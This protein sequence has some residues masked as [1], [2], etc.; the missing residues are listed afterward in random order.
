[1]IEEFI[2]FVYVVVVV[3]F[4]YGLKMFGFFVMVC[5][6][7]VFLCLG[8]GFVFVVMLFFNEIIEY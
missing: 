3:I 2:N 8:M 7:N 1:M 6:G 5:R 4:I